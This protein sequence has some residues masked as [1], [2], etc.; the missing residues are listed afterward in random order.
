[1]NTLIIYAH[2]YEKIRLTYYPN[3]DYINVHTRYVDETYY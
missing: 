2:P 1:M 3:G